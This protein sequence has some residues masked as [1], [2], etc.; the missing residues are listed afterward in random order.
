MQLIKGTSIILYTGNETETVENVLIGEP[1]AGG[2]T[3]GIPKG[4][5]H[6]WTDRKIGFFGE[7]WR[8]VG[9]PIQGIEANIPLCWH[10]KIRAEPLKITGA[11]TIYSAGTYTRHLIDGAFYTDLRGETVQKT[12][13]QNAGV[14]F[15][16]LYCVNN[17]Y[18][19]KTGDIVVLG[20]CPVEIANTAEQPVSQG[21]SALRAYNPAVIRTVTAETIGI[22]P[23]YNIE[24]R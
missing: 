13:A 3:L 11:V 2:Y 21:V 22:A 16:H 1:N 17:V 18:T 24:A 7:L 14:L 4:D 12:G 6:D 23:D 8:T 15:V 10:K 19:P 9:T 20:D 5:A